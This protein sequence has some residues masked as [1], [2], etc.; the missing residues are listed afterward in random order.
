M[1]DP[2]T[3]ETTPPRKR[4]AVAVSPGPLLTDTLSPP[5][6]LPKSGSLPGFSATPQ[7]K[8]TDLLFPGVGD[9]ASVQS[10]EAPLRDDGK[11]EYNIDISRTLAQRATGTMTPQMS[12]PMAQYPQE[13]HL[14]SSGGIP[15]TYRSSGYPNMGSKGYYPMGAEWTDSYGA[16]GSV[17]YALNCPPYQVI[18]GDT[19]P[20]VPSYGHWPS[21]QKGMGQSASVYMEPE[22]NYPYSNGGTTGLVHRP[23]S[24]VPGDSSAY[25]F[26]SIAASLPSAG[27]ER[28]LPNPAAVS[29]TVG[30]LAAPY[31][32]DGLPPGYGHPKSNHSSVS[33]SQPSP[34]SPVDVA[35]AAVA[36]GYANSYDYATAGRPSGHHG[37][38]SADAYGPSSTGGSE[39]IFADSDRSAAT[40]GSVVD[41]TGYTYGGASPAD[42]SSLRRASAGSGL[43]SRS[44]ADSTS[45]TGYAGSDGA[46]THDYHHAAAAAA[47]S[48]SSSHGH[49]RSHRHHAASSH[50]AS[51]RHG[52]HHLAQQQQQQQ[53]PGA[54]A[55]S[56]GTAYGEASGSSNAS[57]GVTGGVGSTAA[58]D[59][60]RLSVSSRR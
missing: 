57:I 18:N 20:I 24:S 6:S 56:G 14:L 13:M 22:A 48:S 46:S 43:T 7:L 8:T 26:S 11:Y 38:I 35:A 59:S 44:T 37:S 40:Q 17:D 55:V 33:G 29:R 1:S 28:L 39:T 23:A 2:Q 45:S 25:S 32:G 50:I 49:H 42:S 3:E 53:L 5:T 52:S 58:A 54:H 10:Q 34:T 60:H 31:R 51:P 15:A 21:R 41:L 4:I 47:T 36:A 27:S 30:S 12:S 16:D 9:A 19:A